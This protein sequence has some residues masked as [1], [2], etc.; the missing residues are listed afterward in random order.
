MKDYIREI[1]DK[2]LSQNDNENRLREYIQKYILFVIYR[3]KIYQ[4]VIFTGGTA[5][6]FLYK[7][8]RYSENL[9]FSISEKARNYDFLNILK[10]IKKELVL[11]GYK[12][13]IKYSI[14]KTV[15]SAFFRFPELLY[16]YGLNPHKNAKISIKLEIDT[17]PPSGSKQEL[18]LYNSTFL[19][20][21]LHYDL[22]SLFSGKLHAL[23]CREYTKGRDWYD[24]LW[25]L[26]NIKDL[27]P[28]HLMLKRAIKQTC[29]RRIEIEKGNWKQI[30]KQEIDQLDIE[31]V[32]KDVK[33]FLENHN[34]IEFLNKESLYQILEKD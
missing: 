1:I 24:L 15:H 25:Y 12:V 19:F 27:E 34:E 9:D 30:L 2:N 21:I 7:L 11:S 17:N 22:P 18:S 31:K 14:D 33:P 23:L 3:K 8:R 16:E 28:N 13:D 6:R 4:N 20:Y 32:K 26:T 5:L 29:K 10:V